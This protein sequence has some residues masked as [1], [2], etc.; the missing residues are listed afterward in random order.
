MKS[1][2]LTIQRAVFCVSNAKI[3]S[4]NKNARVSKTK[5]IKMFDTSAK[6]VPR[7]FIPSPVFDGFPAAAHSVFAL[8]GNIDRRDIAQMS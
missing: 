7:F 6:Q 4:D 5:L 1:R 2:T 3:Y 8:N